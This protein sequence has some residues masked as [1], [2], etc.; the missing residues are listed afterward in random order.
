GPA[1]EPEEEPPGLWLSWPQVFA[2]LAAVAFLAAAVTWVFTGSDGRSAPGEVDVGFYRDMSTHHEQ[3]VQLSMLQLDRGQDPT[4][5]AFATEIL[6]FQNRELGIMGLRLADWGEDG[7]RPDTAMAWMGMPTPPDQMPGMATEAQIDA[8]RAAEGTEA[9]RLFLELMAEHHRGGVHMAAYAAD[10]A[11]DEEVR[12]LAAT[13]ER[14]Q[15]IEINEMAQTADRL[16]LG[17]TIERV[18]VPPEA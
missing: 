9:D 12:R 15:S 13:M 1:G 7:P 17:I 8:L 14:F 18:D 10:H 6:I 11:E 5:M 16:G 3:A 4:V 2:L